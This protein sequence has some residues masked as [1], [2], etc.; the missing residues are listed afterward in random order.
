MFAAGNDFSFEEKRFEHQ[1]G[2]LAN[3]DGVSW[4]RGWESNP[5]MKV[6]QTSPLPLGYRA[7]TSSISELLRATSRESGIERSAAALQNGLK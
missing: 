6:L 5:R 1:T 4:R 2:E 3:L 7:E